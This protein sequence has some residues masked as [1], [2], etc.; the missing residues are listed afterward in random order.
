MRLNAEEKKRLAAGASFLDERIAGAVVPDGPGGGE[1]AEKLLLRWKA[2]TSTGPEFKGFYRRLKISGASVDMV[3]PLLG[4]VSWNEKFPLPDWLETLDDFFEQFPFDYGRRLDGLPSG[5]VSDARQTPFQ[6]ALLPF[7]TLCRE[8]FIKKT[9]GRTG[10]LAA[11]AVADWLRHLLGHFLTNFGPALL[12][13]FDLVRHKGFGAFADTAAAASEEGAAGYIRFT[14]DLLSGG[15]LELFIRYPVAARLAATFCDRQSSYFAAFA[16][17][18]ETDAEKIREIFNGGKETGPVKNIKMGI[19]DEHDGGKSVIRAEFECGLILFYKPRSCGIDLLWEKTLRWCGSKLSG[20]C[21]RTPLH[22]ECGGHCWAESIE[23]SPLANADEARAYYYRAGA[24]LALTYVM[25][26]TDFHQENLIACGAHPVLV[27]LE[28]IL[29]PLVR[30]FNYEA[31]TDEERSSYLGLDGDSVLRSGMLPMWT[32][33]SKEVSRD[34]GALT[35]DDNASYSRREWV[36]INTD[37]MRRE[38]HDR[39]NNPSPNVPHSG[40][41]P[42]LVKCHMDDLLKGFREVCA[43]IMA[44]RSEFIGAAGPLKN[45]SKTVMRYIP[46]DSQI[47]ANMIDRLRSPHLLRS[48]AAFSAEVEG[49]S[50]PFLNNVPPTKNEKLWKIFDAERRSLLFLNIPLF[51]F[52]SGGTSVFDSSG[53]ICADYFL[54]NAVEEAERRA[55]KLSPEDVDFQCDLI[56]ASIACIYPDHIKAAPAAS[57]MRTLEDYRGPAEP[58][59]GFIACASLIAGKISERAVVRNGAPQWLTIKYDPAKNHSFIGPVDIT[60]YEGTSGIGLFLASFEKVTGDRRHHGLAKNCFLELRRLIGDE[61]A[62]WRIRKALSGYAA[63]LL[64]ALLA[65]YRAGFCLSEDELCV[66]AKKGFAMLSE[67]AVENDSALDAISG[68]AGTLLTLVELY[69][70]FRDEKFLAL[71]GKCGLHLLDRR[72]EFEGRLLWPSSYAYKPLT[73][74]AHGAAGYAAALLKLYGRA[75]DERFREAAMAAIDYETASFRQDFINWPDFRINRDLKPGET[76]FMSGWCSGAPGIGLA[77]LLT[78]DCADGPGI[79][80]DIANAIAFTMS[81]TGGYHARDHLC[82]GFCGRIDF[83]AE[84]SAVLGETRLMDEAARQLSFV[85]SAAEE[86]GRYSFP[87]DET[88]SVFTPGLFTGLAGVGFTALRLAA[89]DE[90]PTVLVPRL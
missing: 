84:A 88:K 48:G 20:F 11:G 68:S 89:P 43:A 59:G 22:L 39:K 62:S 85:I 81:Q 78:L 21:W 16:R 47:Y 50:K 33:V 49:L 34:Y 87:V 7:V 24:V 25:G 83:L 14:S 15:W 44:N 61:K 28:T 9:D 1:D 60:L 51:E 27:D 69:D 6:H 66:D 72:V 23:N 75:G 90:I 5:S 52:I 71:A 2:L 36:Y 65:M 41:V 26:G 31:M 79:R 32:P 19:S 70:H 76:A 18:L 8:Y 29:R 13:A 3:K 30:P 74:F 46:R 10:R 86:R 38:Y 42:V 53:E 45:F 12:S 55:L 57:V 54:K 56:T 73:G 64:G 37:R 77:R 80:Q 40:G 82:C 58:S 4:E 35:P 67:E 63:G 17:D